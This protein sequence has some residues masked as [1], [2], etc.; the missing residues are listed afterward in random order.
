LTEKLDNVKEL[1]S[2]ND[3]IYIT[4]ADSAGQARMYNYQ[5]APVAL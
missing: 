4:E 5:K 2:R 3:L 1:V